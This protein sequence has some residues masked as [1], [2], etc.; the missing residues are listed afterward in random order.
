VVDAQIGYKFSKH[1]TMVLDGLN[2][3]NSRA[4]DIAYYYASRLP[5]EPL[6]GVNDVHFKPLEPISARLSL[7]YYF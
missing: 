5:G 4:S 6:Q 7:I 2:L 1:V 3:N